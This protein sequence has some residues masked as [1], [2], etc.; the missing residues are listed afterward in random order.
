VAF[1]FLLVVK[2]KLLKTGGNKMGDTPRLNFPYIVSSHILDALVQPVIEGALVNTPPANP[3]AGVLYVVGRSPNGAWT[4]KAECLAQY[5]N[6]VWTFYVP[7]EGLTA[8]NKA[9]K[10]RWYYSGTEWSELSDDQHGKR[11]DNRIK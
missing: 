5:V 11:T 6:D 1:F 2:P 9:S 4:G 7:F 10:S 8:W 3:T